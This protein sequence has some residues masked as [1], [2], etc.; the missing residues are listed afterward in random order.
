MILR[1]VRP[2][3]PCGPPTT[4]RPVGLIRYLI[5]PLIEFLGQHRLDHFLDHR[6]PQPALLD[7]RRVLRR[8]HDGVDGM[9][10]AVDVAQGDLRFGVRT[11]P[12]KAAVAAQLGLALDQP[13]RI[14][15]GGRHQDRRLVA[16]VAEH[17][18]L[19]AGT[20]VEVVVLGL[21][22]A[23]GDV[24]AL[25]VIADLHRAALVVD[26]VLGVV[27]ADALDG[28][29]H[30]LDVVDVGGRGDLARQQHQSGGA[31][32]FRGDP[33]FG[34]LR[35]QGIQD[36]VR[37]L[38]GNLVGMTFRNRFGREQ[39]VAHCFSMKCDRPWAQAGTGRHVS[40]R[41]QLRRS[42]DALADVCGCGRR[43]RVGPW[44]EPAARPCTSATPQVVPLTQWR[45][46][47]IERQNP[48]SAELGHVSQNAGMLMWLLRSLALLPLWLLQAVG[49]AGGWAAYALSGGFRRKTVD[50]LR[51]AGLYTPHL[52]WASAAAAGKAA[53]ETCYIWFRSLDGLLRKCQLNDLRASRRSNRGGAGSRLPAGDHHPDVRTSAASR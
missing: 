9:R 10:P 11:Q 50:N 17:Q 6:F 1:P 38:V 47:Y 16:G 52:A 25:A 13:M 23:L 34:I 35:K 40:R 26:A 39:I 20:L 49:A 30:D 8:E 28:V 24:R 33:R 5:S 48:R 19:V 41:C 22:H 21:V 31:E 44:I 15:D 45:C 7:V 43:T 51:T 3:S 46:N 2:Q 4:K 32:G 53:L 37:Y 29:A 36:G 27:V 18:A 42:R 14:V 12:G